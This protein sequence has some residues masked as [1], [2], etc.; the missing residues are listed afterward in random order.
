MTQLRTHYAHPNKMYKCLKLL[1]RNA[2]SVEKLSSVRNFSSETG[3][4]LLAINIITVIFQGS[5]GTN[6]N[7]YSNIC[8][9]RKFSVLKVIVADCLLCG[10]RRYSYD[11]DFINRSMI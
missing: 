9:N 4:I 10:K 11:Q 3:C 7:C 6:L 8:F 1:P 2:N 5:F